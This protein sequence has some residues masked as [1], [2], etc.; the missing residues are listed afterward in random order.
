MEKMD[1]SLEAFLENERKKN[2]EFDCWSNPEKELTSLETILDILHCV[3]EGMAYLEQKEVV[4]RDLR[5]SNVLLLNTENN[6][7]IAKI[8]DF[9]L[10][11]FKAKYD[12]YD[13]GYQVIFRQVNIQIFTQN[14]VFSTNICS[15]TFSTNTQ[16]FIKI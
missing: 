11:K 9:G 16:I 1:E 10:S 4:H 8:G 12:Y 3:V 13:H 6:K 2:S 15:R 7:K 14:L 5:T